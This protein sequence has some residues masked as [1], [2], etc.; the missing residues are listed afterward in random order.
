MLNP[1]NRE[2]YLSALKP[3]EEYE[4]EA[5]VAAT[6][7]LDL[8]TLLLA[9]VSFA[10]SEFQ[11]ESEINLDL[12]TILESLRRTADKMAV[13][14][15]SGRIQIPKADNLLYSYLERAVVEVMPPDPQKG[16]FHPKFWLLRFA[17]P[18]K[19][20]VY[21]LICLSRNLTFDQSW[22]TILVMDGEVAQHRKKGYSV[23]R[24][25][26]DLVS[27]LPALAVNETASHVSGVLETITGDL[28]RVRFEPPSSFSA[29]SFRPVGIPGY[30]RMK[31]EENDRL[32]VI[33]PFLS[34]RALVSLA[35]TSKK[36]EAVLVSSPDSLD[37]L[38]RGTLDK[39]SRIYAFE[40]LP[41]EPEEENEHPETEERPRGLHTKLILAE[42]GGNTK[43]WT[44]SANA[45]DPVFTKPGN[46]EFMVELEGRRKDT[47]INCLLGE[48]D[49]LL[50][51]LR[52]HV[53]P[54]EPEEQEPVSRRLE[55]QLEEARRALA[56]A[57]LQLRAYPLDKDDNFALVL[58]RSN[59]RDLSV[60]AD[61]KARCWPISLSKDTRAQNIP[62]DAGAEVSFAALSLESITSFMAFE[63]IAEEENQK[64][65]VRF[66]LNLPLSGL[67][68]NRHD[69]VLYKI[70]SNRGSF[71][72]YLLLLLSEGES[73][74]PDLYWAL[75][76][77]GGSKK[78]SEG[79]P[80]LPLFE[81][82]VRAVSRHP[83]KIDRIARLIDDLR[84]TEKGREA[85]PEGFNEI[86]EP[87]IAA[88]K[89]VEG[90]G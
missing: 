26:A 64:E 47:G 89:K 73:S 48:E 56:G 69:H 45:T 60:L 74:Q 86:W 49:S 24:P 51:L 85:L 80:A 75:M 59:S 23:N 8:L 34:D 84:Q 13:F 62:V 27:Y 15:Q 37:T 63:L 2:L 5:G 43:L 35:N 50:K 87:I 41:V 1:D 55:Q 65:V 44:G 7:S 83:E 79:P 33:S 58:T 38:Q 67:P 31:I 76:E 77:E 71:I 36:G 39:F 11:N 6:Y 70:I 32:L 53:P 30:R 17:S 88:R 68:E 78:A 28:P 57:G 66:V 12:T 25:L 81:E 22:D 21:R 52:P 29:Y 90:N 3:P 46:I 20:P 16:V 54:A 61:I 14:C 4:F 72:R 40:D 42:Y 10:L 18:G 9:P 82:L 19:P